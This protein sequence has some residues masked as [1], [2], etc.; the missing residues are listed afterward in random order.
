MKQLECIFVHEHVT[1]I[2]AFVEIKSQKLLN[3]GIRENFIPQ[4]N[5]IYGKFREKANYVVE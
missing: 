3:R 1:K 5:C 4:K 2:L